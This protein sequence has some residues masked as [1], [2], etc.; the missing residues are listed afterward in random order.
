M[1][2]VY[3]TFFRQMIPIYKFPTLKDVFIFLTGCF[4]VPPLGF[5]RGSS[6]DTFHDTDS[7]PDVYMC[8]DIHVAILFSY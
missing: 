1:I 7:F 6:K 3:L 5:S 2:V 4:E 8:T